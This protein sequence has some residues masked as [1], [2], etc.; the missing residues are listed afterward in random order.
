MDGDM[1]PTSSNQHTN[2]GPAH[3]NQ[4]YMHVIL[5]GT[6][7]GAFTSDLHPSPNDQDDSDGSVPG[8]LFS[9]AVRCMHTD[10]F[11]TCIV[12]QMILKTNSP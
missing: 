3:T 10:I 8:S 4:G 2:P 11:K 9:E 1:V 7:D 12:S 6:I 5:L